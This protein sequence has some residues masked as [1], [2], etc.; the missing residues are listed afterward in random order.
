MTRKLQKTSK[1]STDAMVKAVQKRQSVPLPDG[2]ELRSDEELLIWEQFTAT[3]SIDDWTDL[4]LIL[5]LKMTYLEADIREA[6]KDIDRRGFV[7][8]NQRGTEIE[9]PMLRVIDTMARQQ[10][11][12]I[13]SMSLTQTGGDARTKRDG[14]IS[15]KKAEA[16]IKDR[17]VVS[18]LAM[19]D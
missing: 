1:N 17:G 5:V 12:Y 6:R 4:D 18:L 13:R 16:I 19:P 11:A 14:A 3:R 7:I 8:V 15:E 10:L 9:N 2:V